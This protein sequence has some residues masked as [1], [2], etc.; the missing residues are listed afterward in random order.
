MQK[1]KVYKGNLKI[2]DI[3][4]PC[5]VKNG[6][7]IISQKSTNAALK[8]PEGGGSR[9]LPRIIDIK[10]LEPYISDELLGQVTSLIE[11]PGIKGFDAKVLPGV[12]EVWL[13]ARDAGVLTERQLNTAKQAEILMRGLANIG[14][15]ALIDEATG[16]QEIRDKQAL[17]KILDKYL[18]DE[19]AKWTKRFPDEF[20]KELFR[21][22]NLNYPTPLGRKPQYIGKIINDIVY[23]R[24]APGVLEELKSKNPSND[25]GIRKRKHHQYLTKDFGHPKLKEYLS[26]IIFLMKTCS[27]YRE[28][29]NRLARAVPQHNETMPLPIEISS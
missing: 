14:I 7:R 9:N 27:T 28:F 6:V 1:D 5:A 20:Y 13:K 15:T 4:I 3:T 18:T 8:R 23:S 25:K 17:Q 24:L 22:R 16:Y 19:W 29:H 10:A 21:L 12:C 11:A 2:G 26:Q